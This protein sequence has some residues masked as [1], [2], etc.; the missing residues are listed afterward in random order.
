[1]QISLHCAVPI[2]EN[3]FEA[4]CGR[5]RRDSKAAISRVETRKTN[6]ARKSGKKKRGELMDSKPG[7]GTNGIIADTDR[8]REGRIL[9]RLAPASV[10]RMGGA[11]VKKE[12]RGSYAVMPL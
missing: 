10:A 9:P 7:L 2:R 1:M 5:G 6:V 11:L 8:S 3:N 12:A 4:K